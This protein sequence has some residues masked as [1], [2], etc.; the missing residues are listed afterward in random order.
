MNQKKVAIV[1]DALC[2][3]GGAERVALRML[4][5]F[6]EGEFFTSV[7]LP[8]NTYSDYKKKRINVL[9]NSHL[10][11]TEK[12]FK[13]LY[14]YWLSQIQKLDFSSFDIVLSSSTYL[15]KFIKVPKEVKHISYIHAPFRLL[16]K[17]ESYYSSSLPI[18]IYLLPLVKLFLPK[19]RYW[20]KER[21]EMLPS[22]VT[23]SNNMQNEILKVYGR[24]SLVLYPP[25]DVNS[26]PNLQDTSDYYIAIGRLISHKRFD[27]VI[28]ACNKL[29]RRLVIIGD[30]P[31]RIALEKKAGPTIS[32]LGRVD[33][34]IL[35][36]VLS[37][38]RAL[39]FPSNEDFGIV[40]LEAQACGVPVIAFGL[41]GVLETVSE[42]IS[43][44]FF[45]EQS[46]QA[47][48]EKIIEFE[49]LNFSP[50]QIRSQVERFDVKYF[51]RSLRELVGI[52]C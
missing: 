48:M 11:K 32:F 8:N 52:N 33:D 47:V 13:L 19:L 16:W 42:Y 22:I 21:T 20:D 37:K 26:F 43:G 27:I 2:I 1:H 14:P 39:I 45:K 17:P 30:G 35:R 29:Q 51:M 31:E 10:I 44:I 7:Y 23:N 50:T 15:A 46:A 24:K 28:E 49:R 40:P 12:Q 3:A 6:P 38:A 5:T 34:L 4:E 9:Q 36:D 18:P 25:I 41:G